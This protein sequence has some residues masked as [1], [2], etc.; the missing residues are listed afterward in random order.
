MISKILVEIFV[1]IE[2]VYHTCTVAQMKRARPG[3]LLEVYEKSLDSI[4]SKSSSAR[5]I[6]HVCNYVHVSILAHLQKNAFEHHQSIL[7]TD[8]INKLNDFVR[9]WPILEDEMGIQ[10]INDEVII[11]LRKM[12]IYKAKESHT[13]K[14]TNTR[15][16]VQLSSVLAPS[17]N[18]RNPDDIIADLMERER[19]LKRT[20]LLTNI[21]Q[22]LSLVQPITQRLE[23]VLERLEHYG[24]LNLTTVSYSLEDNLSRNS[25]MKDFSAITSMAYEASILTRLQAHLSKLSSV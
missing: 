15:K 8:T 23:F 16:P 20:K 5:S 7:D 12:S 22:Y 11:A 10:S 3:D 6:L 1:L 21:S 19:D 18:V 2:V 17:Q 14:T 4:M 25:H 13:N 24:R 9:I